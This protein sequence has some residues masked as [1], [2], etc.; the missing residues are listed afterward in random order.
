MVSERDRFPSRLRAFSGITSPALQ[1]AFR[2]VGDALNALL[3]VSVFSFSTPESN[4][5]A[6]PGT[7]GLNLATNVGSAVSALW[8]KTAGSRNTGWRPLG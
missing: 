3:P 2:E 4:V 5:T 8:V 7:L 6:T 1:Q